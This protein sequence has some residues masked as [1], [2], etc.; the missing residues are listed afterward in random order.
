LLLHI[1]LWA[2]AQFIP[3]P[4]PLTEVRGNG[5]YILI[6]TV[7][8]TPEGFFNSGLMVFRAIKNIS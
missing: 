3:I 1:N 8:E 2:K 5:I 7:L 4:L 6:L